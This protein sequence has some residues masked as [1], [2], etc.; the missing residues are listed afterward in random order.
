MSGELGKISGSPFNLQKKEKNMK[1]I[2]TISREFGSGGRELAKRLS[3][4]LGFRYVDKDIISNIIQRYGYSQ[5][6]IDS[7]E[8]IGNDDFPYTTCRSF[9]LYSAHQ[10]QATDLLVLEQKII[11][12]LATQENCVI[13]GRGADIILRELN[14][15]NIF[16][17]ATT[18]SK[19]AR[20]RK[21]QL[22]KEILKDADILKQAKTIDKARKKHL[23]LLGSDGW[24]KKENYNLLVNTS[25]L[26]IKNLVETVASFSKEYFKEKQ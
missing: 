18:E 1:Q 15:L 7:I 11:K 19:I 26:E 13:V 9:G 21:K 10:K 5:N 23:L 14:P 6:Y 24:G 12:K 2:I 4:R 16:V 8:K 25:G 20:C 22:T 3:E 17:Y